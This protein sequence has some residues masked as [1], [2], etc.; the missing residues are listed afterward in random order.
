M[1]TADGRQVVKE[2]KITSDSILNHKAQVIG[3]PGNGFAI[4]RTTTTGQGRDIVLDIYSATGK[5]L[6]QGVTVNQQQ[7]GTQEFGSIGLTKN[8]EIVITWQTAHNGISSIN[9]R[10]FSA[11]D[12]SALGDE[13]VVSEGLKGQHKAVSVSTDEHGKVVTLWNHYGTNSDA[14]GIYLNIEGNHAGEKIKTSASLTLTVMMP[15]N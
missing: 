11:Q 1:F 6:Q 3:L 12:G 9:A 7:P 14:D 5:A 2:T 10:K 4:T 13:Y 8:N 15:L